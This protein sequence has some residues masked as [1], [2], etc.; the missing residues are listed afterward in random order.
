MPTKGKTKEIWQLFCPKCLSKIFRN[1]DI[2]F[3][4]LTSKM[5]MSE[6][7]QSGIFGNWFMLVLCEERIRSYLSGERYCVSL[8]KLTRFLRYLLLL[9][10]YRSLLV[11]SSEGQNFRDRPYTF[12]YMS[13]IKKTRLT[14]PQ[15][16]SNMYSTSP[17]I[18][19]PLTLFHIGGG[20][21]TP[22]PNALSQISKKIADWRPALF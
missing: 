7:Y 2:F 11:E 9:F 12:F 10:L 18:F 17:L 20:I 16:C 8:Q 1:I 6:I 13:R 5:H 21:F 15:K 22:P 14:L 19:A 4:N 3:R